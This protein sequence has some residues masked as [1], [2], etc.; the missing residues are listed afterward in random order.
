MAYANF[1]D[2]TYSNKKEYVEWITEAK[3][4]ETRDRRIA[5]SVEWLEEGKARNWKYMK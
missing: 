5:T 4:S 1:K 2:F 3:T